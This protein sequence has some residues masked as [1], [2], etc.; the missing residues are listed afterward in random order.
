MYLWSGIIY[1]CVCIYIYRVSQDECARLREGV[2]LMLKYTDITQNTYIQSWTVTDIMAR[3]VWNFDSCYT[4]GNGRFCDRPNRSRLS[5]VFHGSTANAESV[6]KIGVT[7]RAINAAIGKIDLKKISAKRNPPNAIKI[8]SRCFAANSG[9]SRNFHVL[10]SDA[11]N[12]N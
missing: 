10:F 4:N 8:S 3:E 7:V 12:K 2:F 5:K 1:V 11:Y 6:T 9:F